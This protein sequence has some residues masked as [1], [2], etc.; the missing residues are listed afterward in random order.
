MLAISE[1]PSE[2]L[3]HSWKEIFLN[4]LDTDLKIGSGKRTKL[5]Q[6]QKKKKNPDNSGYSWLLHIVLILYII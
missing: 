3:D 1:I 6:K 5:E 4:S 2:L